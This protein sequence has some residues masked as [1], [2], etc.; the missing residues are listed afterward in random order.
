MPPVAS[1][2]EN[3]SRSGVTSFSVLYR[4]RKAQTS[5]TFD[6]RPE[7][8]QFQL[9][10]KMLGV[11]KA[12][13]AVEAGETIEDMLT[14]DELAATFF[15]RKAR[16]V[17]S[18]TMDDYRRDY[19]NWIQPTFGHLPADSVD[20][21]MVQEWVDHMT[22]PG[23]LASKTAADKHMVLHSMYDF[24]KAKSRKL[25]TQNPCLETTFPRRAKKPPKGTTVAEWRALLDAAEA[26]NPDARDLVLFLGSTAWRFSEATALAV[27]DVEDD[28]D[29]VH[30][31]VT[32]VFRMVEYRQVLVEDAAKSFAGFR[33]VPVPNGEA[34]DMLRRRMAGKAPG[35]YVFTHS[36]GGPWNQNAFLR[37]TWPA[38]VAD[39]GLLERKPTP[40]WLRHMAVAVL[41]AAGATAS[42]IQRYVGH[43]DVSTTLNTYGGMLGGLAG[44]VLA[45]VDLILS[46]HGPRGLDIT[47]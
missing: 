5:L 13:A 28:G 36:R 27:R 24:G 32:R 20:E 29:R 1:I 39:A 12:L 11:D 30:V 17:T 19:A 34:A 4:H 8:E 26:R 22:G 10:I 38:I 41:A 33:R 21:V 16:D 45:N 15:E 7:A 14:V 6:T 3:R 43:E 47:G 25:V 35:E 18:R 2:R 37:G 42:Q 40:H 31:N 46:G 44:D 23:G 9:L